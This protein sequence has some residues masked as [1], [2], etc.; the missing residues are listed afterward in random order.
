MIEPDSSLDKPESKE[1]SGWEFVSPPLSV[2]DMI[3]QLKKV[4]E[5]AGY[6]GCYTNSS[7]GLHI[8]V[9]IPGYSI[10]KLD[11]IK[12]A[13]FLGDEYVSKEFGRLG[14]TYAK[15]AMAEIKSRIAPDREYLQKRMMNGVRLGM[16]EIASKLIHSGETEKYMSINTKE[17]RIE[18]R[19]PGGDWLDTDINK[20]INTMLR[21]IV[22][23]DIALD[24][25]KEKKEYAKKFF[26][27]LKGGKTV[28]WYDP[29]DPANQ[30]N[31]TNYT[32]IPK[33]GFKQM[34]MDED[35]ILRYFVQYVTTGLPKAALKSF[36]RQAQMRRQDQKTPPAP[37]ISDATPASASASTA[38]AAPSTGGQSYEI[39]YTPGQSSSDRVVH[40]FTAASPRGAERYAQNWADEHDIAARYRLQL[41]GGPRGGQVGT[42][43]ITYT[44]DGQEQ[45]TVVDANSRREATEFFQQNWPT[46]A[47]IVRLE[48]MS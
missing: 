39:I 12:L 14:S 19:S 27:L 20:L 45:Q 5:W 15:S 4:K 28:I 46:T 16:M 37:K 9:S 24:P 7:T 42:Y 18:F 6:A 32:T 48:L 47:Q 22:A 41:V 25:E 33:R 21:F 44:Q 26:E 34:V 38:A 13:L 10:E 11:Y 3:N 1:D 8:N 31:V 40:T 43:K 17:N 36:I 35:P 2:E 30:K 23:M 29:K